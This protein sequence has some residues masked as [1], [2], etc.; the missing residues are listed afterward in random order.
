M[1]T[2]PIDYRAVL[3]DIEN[4]IAKLQSAAD[5]IKEILAIVEVAPATPGASGPGAG[6]DDFFGMSIGDATKKHLSNAKRKQN[7]FEIVKALEEVE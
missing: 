6:S 2:N 1:S 4:R 3:T 7:I 5:A